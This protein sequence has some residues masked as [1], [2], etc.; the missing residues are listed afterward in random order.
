MKYWFFQ[1][2]ILIS[3]FIGTPSSKS[4]HQYH[5]KKYLEKPK[6][7]SSS[8]AKAKPSAY[9]TDSFARPIMDH[10]SIRRICDFGQDADGK[11][12]PKVIFMVIYH[13]TI[14]KQSSKNKSKMLLPTCGILNSSPK[15]ATTRPQS[16]EYWRSLGNFHGVSKGS[17]PQC[18]LLQE[19]AGLM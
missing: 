1:N 18:P 5:Q 6:V 16:T 8:K 13:G 3:W 2:G 17:N 11:S 14:R 12:E 7:L 4:L 15:Q 9:L 10:L 19:I